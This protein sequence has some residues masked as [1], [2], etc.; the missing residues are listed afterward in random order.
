MSSKLA[1]MVR[2]AETRGEV[3]NVFKSAEYMEAS[4]IEVILAS[5]LLG[6]RLISFRLDDVESRLAK[7]VERLG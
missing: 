5:T 7:I 1:D 6:F 3:E 2:T 4:G